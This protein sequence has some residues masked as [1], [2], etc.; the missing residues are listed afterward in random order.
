MHPVGRSLVSM[1]AVCMVVSAIG[2]SARSEPYPR[3]WPPLQRLASTCDA[4]SGSYRDRGQ[5]ANIPSPFFSSLTEVLFGE[6]PKS[7]RPE[8]LT[9][10]F[11]RSGELQIVISGPENQSLTYTL[12]S[13]ADQFVCRA[14]TL[15]IYRSAKWSGTG[16][17][18]GAGRHSGTV[19]LD[20]IDGG[21]V[22]RSDARRLALIGFVVPIASRE[23]RWYRF[24]RD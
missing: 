12:T 4:L 3:T 5:F 2:C 9:L 19:E 6:Q 17:A 21:L 10:S 16:A 13:G 23:Q 8:R 20:R 15:I 1:A 7:W 24:D 22:V 14:S 18:V 11:P